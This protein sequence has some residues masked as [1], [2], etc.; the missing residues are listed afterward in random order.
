[1]VVTIINGSPRKNGATGKILKE[2]A[3]YL[4]SKGD[5]ELN[6]VDL[7]EYNMRFCKGC[8]ACFRTGECIIKE[9][10][11]EALSHLISRSDG[12]V[13]GSPTYESN[14]HGQVKTMMDRGHFVVEQLLTGKYCFAVSTYENAQ[15]RGVLKVLNRLFSYSGGIIAGNLLAKVIFNKDPFSIKGLRQE[16]DEKM[17]KYYNTMKMKKQKSV[18]GKIFSWMI[19]NFGFKPMVTKH[20]D[21]YEGVMK[22]WAAMGI[23]RETKL[24]NNHL[25]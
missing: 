8:T 5:V 19:L 7:S 16:L 20:V 24:V 25:T 14:V 1:M 10:G 15:G 4:E 3:K 18:V 13:I 12:L 22:K 21:R 23:V 2:M 9:D 11:L 6:Y 17:K